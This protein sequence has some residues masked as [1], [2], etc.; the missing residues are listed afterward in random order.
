MKNWKLGEGNSQIL[1]QFRKV[2]ASYARTF[3][4]KKNH[5]FDLL[6]RNYESGLF[7]E[8]LLKGLLIEL[9][10]RAVSVDSGFIY[11]FEEVENS[12]QLDIIIWDCSKHAAVYRTRN[13]VIVPP[14]SVAVVL[15]VKSSLKKSD[16]TKGLSQLLTVSP[17]D[18]AY[19]SPQ[20]EQGESPPPI[21]KILVS[22]K[23]PTD[24]TIALA[25]ISEFYKSRLAEDQSLVNPLLLTLQNIDP[26]Q[27][28]SEDID[29]R[30]RLFPSLIVSIESK[31]TSFVVGWGPP[32]DVSASRTYGINL[33]RLPYI[34]HQKSMLTTP[35]EKLIYHVLSA[36]YRFIGNTSWP[37]LSAWGD[38]NPVLGVRVGDASEVI[39]AEGRP[40]LDT[41]KLQ[42][43]EQ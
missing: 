16:I 23:G 8:E 37:M 6:G 2:A 3:S 14:E 4:I 17:L 30:R 26:I 31:K 1:A 10:P 21:T 15:E 29:Q 32:D 27:P 22:Y 5:I 11:G 43:V 28:S 41:E 35:F 7:R 42:A 9:L 20:D 39:E 40:L 25:T 38:L 13:F 33:K 34:Y 36:V 19:R 24:S 12:K 18:L